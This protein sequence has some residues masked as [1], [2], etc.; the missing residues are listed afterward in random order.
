MAIRPSHLRSFPTYLEEDHGTRH[1]P[2]HWI[3]L[4]KA[5]APLFRLLLLQRLLHLLLQQLLLQELLLLLC[6]HRI[7]GGVV[8]HGQ[9][10]LRWYLRRRIHLLLEGLLL[11]LLLLLHL[12]LHLLLL[13]VVE[14]GDG[15]CG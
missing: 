11:E 14:V 12:H 13:I 3:R 2:R 6:I 8:I 5:T 7:A 4:R 10:L 9:L 15:N 1:D